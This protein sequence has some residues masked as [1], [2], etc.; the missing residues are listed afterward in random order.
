MSKNKNND[1][2]GLPNQSMNAFL[3]ERLAIELRIQLAGKRLDEAFT[4]SQFDTHLV[5]DNLAIKISFF[6]G[7]AYFQLP[8]LLKLQKKNRLQ[9]FKTAKGNK[10]I[11]VISYPYD[12]RFDIL[13]EQGDILAFYLFGK[14]GQITHYRNN[15]WQETF[16]SKSS[17]IEVYEKT[18][19]QPEE[20][21]LTELRFLS[22][23]DKEL[24]SR[25]NFD[26]QTAI[27]KKKL[28]LAHKSAALK[29]R[30][31]VNKNLKKYTLDYAKG[32][33][34]IAHYDSVLDALDQYSRLYIA[35]QV[36]NQTRNAHIGQLR[37]ELLVLEKKLSAAEKRLLELNRASTYREKADLLM[38]NMWQI[39]KGI[40]T[41]NLKSFDGEKDV[42]IKLQESLTPQAN[43]ERYYTKAKNESKQ[44]AFAQKNK[45]DIQIL[46]NEKKMEMLAFEQID[47][48]KVL[49]KEVEIKVAE[50]DVRLPYKTTVV[51]GFEIRIGKG[52]KDND[53]LL[54][55]YTTKTDTWLHA[56]NVSGS[57]VIIRNPR[58]AK[59]PIDTLEKVAAIAAFYSK[60]KSEGLAAVIFTA[61][62]YIR[63]PKGATPGLVKVD[64]EEVILV[65]PRNYTY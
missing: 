50:K 5:F 6:Q 48:L 60:A 44:R 49:R 26:D 24:L 59:I 55:R 16:P 58:N 9:S 22:L 45:E 2:Q 40:K 57:H 43:A 14:F 30:L 18:I 37:K 32:E 1:E 63:K 11:D 27:G 39:R 7:Q 42:E 21:S 52:A 23:E 33:N 17:K 25:Y 38:A 28:L 34:P 4:T 56:K 61:R 46:H 51:D 10:V 20:S 41:V 8:D 64:K 54:R 31:Y 36:Y 12:R 35:H 19:N 29:K 62:K 15:L 3:I 13:L 65:E 47:S 53:E